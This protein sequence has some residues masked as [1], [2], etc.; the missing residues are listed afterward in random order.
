MEPE[1]SDEG[2][3][4]AGDDPLDLKLEELQAGMHP[5]WRYE[6]LAALRDA[7]H[8]RDLLQ[9]EMAA[10]QNE[11]P[12]AAWLRSHAFITYTR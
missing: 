4:D 6:A 2:S 8:E 5:L 10:S 11:D 3:E 7:E 12:P 1:L 9:M